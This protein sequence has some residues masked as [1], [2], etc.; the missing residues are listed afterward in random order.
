MSITL[1]ASFCGYLVKGM[2]GFANT[3][4]FDAI[5]SF[6]QDNIEITPVDLPLSLVS[7]LLMAWHEHRSVSFRIWGLGALYM[8][9]GIIPGAFFLKTQNPGIIKLILGGL[10]LFLA[11]GM[12][13]KKDTQER[14]PS[15]IVNML[16]GITAGF[17]SGLL[18]IGALI[19]LY[20][21]R[22]TTSVDAFRGTLSVLFIVTNTF[23]LLLYFHTGIL[24]ASTLA[25]TAS[26]IPAMAVGLW[27]GL[28]LSSRLDEAL[29]KKIILFFLILS[30]LSLIALNL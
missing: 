24:T 26:L 23:R 16:I 19:S 10:I 14:K 13:R 18:G 20:I 29:V 17:F 1:L 12:L 25:T 9:I 22:V 5:L 27:A 28:K 3:L 4:V 30:G 2:C 6:W 8:I 15:P 21:A 11:A 7:N